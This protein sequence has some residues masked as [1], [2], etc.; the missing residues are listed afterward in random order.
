M[1]QNRRGRPTGYKMSEESKEKTRQTKLGTERPEKVKQKI[2]D[3]VKNR[4]TG[5]PIEIIMMVDLS[6]C[7]KVLQRYWNI[8]IPNPV[9]GK[10]GWWMREHV[11]L[12]EKEI[13]RKLL[14]NEEVHHI[15]LDKKNNNRNNIIL[16][17]GTTHKKYHTIIRKEF[18]C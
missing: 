12:I 15:D 5:A 18:S 1:K 10:R 14:P 8:Y 9:S 2:S 3:G 13:G 4:N 16:V 7:N 11:A 17:N 6:K